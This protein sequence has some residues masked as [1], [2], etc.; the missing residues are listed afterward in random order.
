MVILNNALSINLDLHPDSIITIL[1]CGSKHSV[2]RMRMRL[3]LGPGLRFVLRVARR[4][5]IHTAPR[6]G[7]DTLITEHCILSWRELEGRCSTPSGLLIEG[8]RKHQAGWG[9]PS[10]RSY[11]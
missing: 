10:N 1:A 5:H 7:T 8:L 3:G 2:F 4:S 6:R 11:A 9:Y